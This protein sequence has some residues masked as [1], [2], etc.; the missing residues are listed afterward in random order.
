MHDAH[1]VIGRRGLRPFGRMP[2]LARAKADLARC[3]LFRNSFVLSTSDRNPSAPVE[4][5][6]YIPKLDAMGQE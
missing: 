1:A 5:T 3:P 6:H 4:A 2:T